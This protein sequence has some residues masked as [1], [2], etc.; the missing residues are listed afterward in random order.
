M[1]EIK[2]PAQASEA[3]VDLDTGHE[4][5][6]IREFD[7]K[8]P[9]WWLATLF[10]TV[11]FGVG[12]WLYY[13]TLAVGP[14]QVAAYEMEMAEAAT[15]AAEKAKARGAITDEVLVAMAGDAK[16]IESGKA[17]YGQYCAACHGPEAGGL[18]GPNLT[19]AY[20]L[21][22]KG[23]PTEIR[24]VVAVGVAAKGMPGWEQMLGAE[25]VEQITA[26][27]YSLK[28][29]NVP[30]KEPQGELAAK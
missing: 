13:H 4:Y 21:N 12:Y 1:S 10:L 15:I 11:F 20:W 18:I 30:G 22:G 23:A 28:G 5:D 2:T 9:N 27:V 26:F 3:G 25:K 16:V 17:L 29:K 24:Q 7:N 19:D 14:G 8:L 6:G